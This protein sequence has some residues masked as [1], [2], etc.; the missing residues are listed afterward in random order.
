VPEIAERYDDIVEAICRHMLD[1][2]TD[3]WLIEKRNAGFG[4]FKS[5][6]S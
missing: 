4:S 3:R 6:G 2:V 5:E 1:K